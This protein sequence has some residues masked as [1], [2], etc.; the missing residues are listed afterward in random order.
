LKEAFE[1]PGGLLKGAD[2]RKESPFEEGE[3][4][5]AIFMLQVRRGIFSRRGKEGGEGNLVW[6]GRT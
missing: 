1:L 3:E 2:E 6:T 4:K 5:L